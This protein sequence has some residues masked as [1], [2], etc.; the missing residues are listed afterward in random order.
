MA[1]T[2]ANIVDEGWERLTAARDRIDDDPTRGQVDPSG[3]GR[4]RSGYRHWRAQLNPLLQ[5]NNLALGQLLLRRHL[6]I[7]ILVSHGLDQQAL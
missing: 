3:R 4:C 6:Q 5:E 7:I 2:Q 1:E